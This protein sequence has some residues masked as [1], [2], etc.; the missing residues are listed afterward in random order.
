[1]NVRINITHM[2]DGGMKGWRD[3]WRVSNVKKD[4]VNLARRQ[5]E[6]V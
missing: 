1:M 2:K 4:I 3:G 5:I 6:C